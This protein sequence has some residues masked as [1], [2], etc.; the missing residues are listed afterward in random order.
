MKKINI[1]SITREKVHGVIAVDDK[2]IW[3]TGNYGSIYYSSDGGVTWTQQVSGIEKGILVDGVLLD[4]KI[5]WVVGLFGT[6]LHTKNGGATWKNRKPIRQGIFS[7]FIFPDQ[8]QGWAVGEWGT[9]LYTVDG[10]DL[11]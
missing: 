4:D 11:E 10:G 1:K 9:V 6:V 3:I 2:N 8:K 7:A 5:G